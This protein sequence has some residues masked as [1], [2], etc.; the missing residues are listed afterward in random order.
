VPP[1]R[2]ETWARG[3]RSAAPVGFFLEV[4][5]GVIVERPL[6]GDPRVRAVERRADGRIAGDLDVTVFWPDLIMDRDGVL[7]EAVSRAA[8]TLLAGRLGHADVPAEI[9]LGC[10]LSWRADVVMR[11][12]EHGGKASL[13]YQSVL[14]VGHP[15]V[16]IPAALFVTIRS[17][18][19]DWRAG[20]E[21]LDSLRWSGRV[22]P[23]LARAEGLLLTS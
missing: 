12:D 20:H 22:T 5:D 9:E 19:D 1:V 4:P 17:A 8:A 6:A 23:S 7:R 15:D 18:A 10:G 13:P 16:R 11:R 14:A 3:S 2:I 21:L